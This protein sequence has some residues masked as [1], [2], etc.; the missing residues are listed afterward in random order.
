VGQPLPSQ[1]PAVVLRSHYN[2]L[3]ALLAVA[4][5]AVVGLSVAVVVVAGDEQEVSEA[6]RAAPMGKI[7]YGEFNPATGRPE[8]VASPRPDESKIAAT[9]GSANGSSTTT[10]GP[11][12]TVVAGAVS[13]R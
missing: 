5:I 1:H 11:D 7:N 6:T 2:A 3:R 10:G 9:I 4:L 12:E 13:G 8:S